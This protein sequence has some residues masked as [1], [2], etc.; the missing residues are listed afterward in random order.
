[1]FKKLQSMK[2]DLNG[3]STCTTL[4][5]Q[6]KVNWPRFLWNIPLPASSSQLHICI[7]FRGRERQRL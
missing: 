7:Y 4:G 2:G 5:I 6:Y 3:L 1:M